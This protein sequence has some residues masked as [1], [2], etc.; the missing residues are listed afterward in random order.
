SSRVVR[1]GSW[2]YD[3]YNCRSADRYSTYPIISGSSLGF[4]VALAPVK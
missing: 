1:G 3:A 4:R 2:W